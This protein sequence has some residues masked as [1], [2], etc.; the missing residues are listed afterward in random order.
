MKTENKIFVVT[1]AG[2]GIGREL[3][4]QLVAK[5]AQV[6]MIDLNQESM[7]ETAS[8]TN[9]EKVTSYIVDISKLESIEKFKDDVLTKYGFVDGIINNA[10]I[11]Q[12]FIPVNQL[13][14]SQIEKIVNIN[15]YGTV[16]MIKT[17]LPHL[18]NRPEGHI[19]NISSMGGFI[20]FPGQ[21]I[22][23]A[24]KAAVKT[25][26]EGLYA[27]LK[28]SNVKVTVVHPGAIAT[29]ISKNSG[30]KM[31][32]QTENKGQKSAMK[33]LPADQ[34]ARIIINGIEK[35]KFRVLVGKDASFLDLFYR[36]SPEKAVNFIV[37]KMSSLMK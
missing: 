15:F 36:I 13:D 10:G 18:L 23:S 22:Y 31:P 33:A 2:S 19:V 8:L 16:Y 20:P 4:L 9:K 11:I 27:E 37:K 34:A 1:G 30:I 3:T 28:N 12:P 5:G 35:N 29:N 32:T 21:T 14:M 26:T 24:T 25:L 17:F 7:N 6:A